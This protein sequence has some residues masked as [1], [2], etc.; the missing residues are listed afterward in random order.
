MGFVATLGVAL[1]LFGG[2][3]LLSNKTV[4]PGPSYGSSDAGVLLNSLII[5]CDKPIGLLGAEFEELDGV[6]A[7]LAD[8]CGPVRALVDDVLLGC[9]GFD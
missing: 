1:G 2:L 4:G 7:G 5:S 9:V 6:V 8:D 3:G